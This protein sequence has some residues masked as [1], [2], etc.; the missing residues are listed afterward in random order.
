MIGRLTSRSASRVPGVASGMEGG[1]GPAQAPPLGRGRAGCRAARSASLALLAAAISAVPEQLRG[2][3]GGPALRPV[4]TSGSLCCGLGP[5]HAA[6]GRVPERW[7]A[8]LCRPQFP[9]MGGRAPSQL[10]VARSWRPGLSLLRRARGAYCPIRMGCAP[11]ARPSS[12]P[13][14]P[15]MPANL[16][17]R[18]CC[19][20]DSWSERLSAPQSCPIMPYLPRLPFAGRQKT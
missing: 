13:G 2:G 19:G 5:G 20:W 4:S 11:A 1:G 3:L 10:Q 14:V 6:A 12:S 15:G 9:L 16:P 8:L 17:V 7:E 18:L